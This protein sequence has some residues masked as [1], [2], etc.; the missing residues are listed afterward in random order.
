MKF[1]WLTDLHFDS[2]KQPERESLKGTLAHASLKYLFITG[3]ISI[4][5][6]ILADLEFL[7]TA[8][9]NTEIYFTLG[10]HDFWGGEFS[11]VR[12]KVKKFCDRYENIH[13]LSVQDEPLFIEIN[14]S[15]V[16]VIGHEGWND[17]GAN[18][19]AMASKMDYLRIKSFHFRDPDEGY[20]SLHY[21]NELN[22]SMLRKIKRKCISEARL[23]AENLG[24]QLQKALRET[25]KVIILTH[26]PPFRSSCKYN[27]KLAVNEWLP[28]YSSQ[29]VGDSIVKTIAQFYDKKVVILCGHT[30]EEAIDGINDNLRVHVGKAD[31]KTVDI[32]SND[33]LD[34]LIL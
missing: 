17:G 27:G 20:F 9:P 4:S 15:K 19:E 11:K 29:T 1:L 6:T 26:I 16:A 12:K 24:S 5:R 14:G 3:D 28:H 13:Y 21:A 2:L 7:L 8:A 33:W 18:W 32:Q 30:H 22:D 31:Y 25:D 23:S 34:W 10:N